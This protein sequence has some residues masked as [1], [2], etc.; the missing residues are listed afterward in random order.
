MISSTRIERAVYGRGVRNPS[1]SESGVSTQ[2]AAGSAG[3][4]WS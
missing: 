3:V 1:E 2:V 4:R